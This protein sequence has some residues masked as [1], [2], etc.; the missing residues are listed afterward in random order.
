MALEDEYQAYQN[1]LEEQSKEADEQEERIKNIEISD[2][3]SHEKSDLCF[4]YCPLYQDGKYCWL[5]ESPKSN[6]L[7]CE[8]ALEE[9]KNEKI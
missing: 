4:Y 1:R 7:A 3:T 8:M 6:A 2:M 9:F 5:G